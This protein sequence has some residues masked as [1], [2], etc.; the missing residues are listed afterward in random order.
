MC[1]C[2]L[3][4][5]SPQPAATNMS[6]LA[7]PTTPTSPTSPAPVTPNTNDPRRRPMPDDIEPPEARSVRARLLEDEAIAYELDSL[8]T[9]TEEEATNY[10]DENGNKRVELTVMTYTRAFGSSSKEYSLC[11]VDGKVGSP[12][13]L[14]NHVPRHLTQN[15]QWS[16]NPQ[17]FEWSIDKRRAFEDFK[18]MKVTPGGTLATYGYLVTW[19]VFFS[20]YNFD[21]DKL[22]A[23]FNNFWSAHGFVFYLKEEARA[24]LQAHQEEIT[25]IQ[26]DDMVMLKKDAGYERLLQ[27]D[28]QLARVGLHKSEYKGER[29]HRCD[30]PQATAPRIAKALSAHLRRIG[31]RNVFIKVISSNNSFPPMVLTV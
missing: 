28:V 21:M 5:V 10:L 3:Q 26:L 25:L 16:R 20:K 27:M 31:Q 9:V 13:E 14:F 12:N 4:L 30:N 17:T 8:F 2:W 11:V 23:T 1:P 15:S 29:V 18:Y 7:Q 6:S 19:D 22:L 24:V